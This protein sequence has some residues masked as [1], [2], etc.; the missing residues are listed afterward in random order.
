MLSKFVRIAFAA[1][2]ALG[3]LA[4]AGPPVDRDTPSGRPERT[5]RGTTP[6]KVQG[7]ITNELINMGYQPRARSDQRAVFEKRDGATGILRMIFELVEVDNSVR[8]IG[9]YLAINNPGTSG[10]FVFPYHNSQENGKP[11]R[12]VLDKVRAALD[13]P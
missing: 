6:S 11:L 12:D 13:K 8:V 5:I 9:T 7:A 3:L 4:C 1:L 10:E 2:L